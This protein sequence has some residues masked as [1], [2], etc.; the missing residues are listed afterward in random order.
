MENIDFD[1]GAKKENKSNKEKPTSPL[2]SEANV[3]TSGLLHRGNDLS[4]C[5]MVEDHGKSAEIRITKGR[6]GDILM[7]KGYSQAEIKELLDY[8]EASYDD[9]SGYAKEINPM[10]AFMS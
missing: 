1:F 7:N 10:K 8:F 6:S 2:S 4:I 9:I 3:S 5:I